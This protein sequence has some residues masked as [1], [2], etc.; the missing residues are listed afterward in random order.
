MRVAPIHTEC[1]F[2]NA[3]PFQTA[4][5]GSLIR[6]IFIYPRVYLGFGRRAGVDV[7]RQCKFF[8]CIMWT[9]MTHII[10][11]FVRSRVDAY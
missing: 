3:G 5:V 11:R 1:S 6:I 9:E 4:T 7:M 2:I 8:C 10:M